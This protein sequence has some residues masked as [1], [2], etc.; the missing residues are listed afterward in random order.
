MQQEKDYIKREIEKLLLFLKKLVDKISS[1]NSTEIETSDLKAIPSELNFNL[2]KIISISLENFS[3]EV[4]ELD[5]SILEE[6]TNLF[7]SLAK[8]SSNKNKEIHL[9]K[10]LILLNL[11]DEK[12]KTFSFERIALKQEIERL[13]PR[14][15]KS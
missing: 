10:A 5:S 1:G 3:E 9:K 15:T 8:K 14:E 2:T 4:K 6:L 13:V 12:D 11:I 7:V